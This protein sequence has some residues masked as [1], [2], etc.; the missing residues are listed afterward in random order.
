MRVTARCAELRGN[1]LT[2]DCTA[3]DGDG[4]VLGRGTTVQ[5]VLSEQSLQ[6]R[7]G[8]RPRVHRQA[9]SCDMLPD[10]R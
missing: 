2:C 8:E 6:A 9:G 5:V 7:I 4:H 3:V 1:R 10:A